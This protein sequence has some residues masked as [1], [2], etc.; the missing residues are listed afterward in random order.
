MPKV[1]KIKD[2]LVVLGGSVCTDYGKDVTKCLVEN[3]AAKGVHIVSGLETEI[4]FLA[5][6]LSLGAGGK[7]SGFLAGSVKKAKKIKPVRDLIHR[8]AEDKN[9]S[10]YVPSGK[11]R[12]VGNPFLD[13]DRVMITACDAVLVTEALLGSRIF[14]AVEFALEN[15]KTI[16]AVPCSSFKYTS[17]GA[18]F[19]LE[20]GALLVRNHMTILTNL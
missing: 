20:T 10:L 8:L 13:R 4:S 18:S 11:M 3:L 17:R 14:Y 12:Q 2:S 1:S 16:F 19:L 9:G 6:N 15:N 5:L 7:A